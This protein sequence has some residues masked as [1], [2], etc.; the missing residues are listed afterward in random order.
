MESVAAFVRCIPK[1]TSNDARTSEDLQIAEDIGTSSN[2]A[3]RFLDSLIRNA[4]D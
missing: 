4:V 1:Q 3:T 2:G